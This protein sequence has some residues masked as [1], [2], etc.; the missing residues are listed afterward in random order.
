MSD[1]G[2]LSRSFWTWFRICG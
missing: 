2:W 1:P